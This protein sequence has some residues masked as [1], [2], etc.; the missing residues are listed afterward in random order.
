MSNSSFN[1]SSF[2]PVDTKLVL[3]NS[4]QVD[5][6]F[7]SAFVTSIDAELWSEQGDSYAESQQSMTDGLNDS[8]V[9][10]TG[11][12]SDQNLIC[13]IAVTGETGSDNLVHVSIDW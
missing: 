5:I 9:L 7:S 6:T 8:A 10:F 13:R 1:V 11:F 3:S 4:T 2:G 12:P